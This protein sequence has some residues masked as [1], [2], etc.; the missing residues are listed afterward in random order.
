M[1]ASEVLLYGLTKFV[2]AVYL[3][4]QVGLATLDGADRLGHVP[5][6]FGKNLGGQ[7]RITSYNVCY[8][9]L[10]RQQTAAD[11]EIETI[12][13]YKLQYGIASAFLDLFVTTDG[14]TRHPAVVD[15]YREDEAIEL[16]PDENMHDI[17]VETI[18]QLAKQR[19][20]LLGAGIMRN[21]F[22]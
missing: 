1:L 21:N 5:D 11:A 10:L 15:Y 3:H 4:L 13:L 2:A 19:G 9:K 6:R 8:T 18:A 16:G 17:M 7:G 12:R 20:Y 14:I 22:V